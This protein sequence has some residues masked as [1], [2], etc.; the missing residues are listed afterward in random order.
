M[1]NRHVPVVFFLAFLFAWPVAGYPQGI[2]A[3]YSQGKFLVAERSLTDPNFAET[4]VLMLAHNRDGAMGLV[5]NRPTAVMPSEVLPDLKM[6]EKYD[7]NLYLGGPVALNGLVLLIRSDESLEDAANVFG[8]V[9]VSASLELLNE[10]I[11]KTKGETAVR[12]YVGHSGWGPG[13]LDAELKRG[14]W[15]VVPADEDFVFSVEPEDVWQQVI[16][17]EKP[18]NVMRGVPEST[19]SIPAP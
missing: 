16:P 2:S 9:H 14:D 17:P 11:N 19:D 13:Q 10:M 12:L 7:G 5:I 3:K 15:A 4:V 8:S 6:L 1:T 18:L